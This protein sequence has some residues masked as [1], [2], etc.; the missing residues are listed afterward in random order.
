M[1]VVPKDITAAIEA[2]HNTPTKIVLEFAG[3]GSMALAWLHSIG[4][5][6]RTVLEATD[7][8]AA[9]S[10]VDLLQFKAEKFV[11]RGVAMAMATAAY[12]RAQTLAEPGSL[13]AGIGCTATI[14]TD[15]TKR[16]EHRCWVAAYSP[17]GLL[18]LELQL[19]KGRRDRVEEEQLVSRLILQAIAETCGVD[20][21]LVAPLTD[22]AV[23]E[24]IV[25]NLEPVDLLDQLLAQAV[26]TVT[27][28]PNGHLLADERVEQAVMLSGS[29][30]PLHQ[31][32]RQMAEI[33][34]KKLDRSLYFELPLINADKSPIEPAEALRRGAQ[35]L[36]YAP[37]LYTGAP[38]F[39][40]KAQIFPNTVFIVGYDT[41]ARLVE[42]R[43]YNHN[44]AQ[45]QAAFEQIRA[46]GCRFFVAGR[47]KNGRFLTWQDLNLPTELHDLFDG[48]TEQEFRVDVSSTE[49]RGQ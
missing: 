29:F 32:H 21:S 22:L 41:A 39:K 47:L 36:D 35:F 49:L 18:T 14:A 38:L 20:Q 19:T 28:S 11:S 42:P 9:A 3:A 45:M 44:P 12:Q 13:L 6:S 7:R 37:L 23:E 25:K 30:N 40:Q 10:L 26:Q 5:S 2:I 46:A 24:T 31:G 33:A 1:T 8:Y 16:G 15:R 34:A 4:G 43:F 27:L 48:T 17:A